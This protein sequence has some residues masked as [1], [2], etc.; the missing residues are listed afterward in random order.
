MDGERRLKLATRFVWFISQPLSTLWVLALALA[1]ST[2]IA[3]VS[4]DRLY[5]EGVLGLST[6]SGVIHLV[7]RVRGVPAWPWSHPVQQ[8][9]DTATSTSA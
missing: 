4:G 9:N 7:A 2:L 6:I 1:A 3:S 8:Q 5:W